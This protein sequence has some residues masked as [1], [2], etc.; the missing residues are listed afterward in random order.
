MPEIPTEIERKSSSVILKRGRTIRKRSDILRPRKYPSDS[1]LEIHQN[2]S[3]AKFSAVQ[4]GERLLSGTEVEFCPLINTRLINQEPSKRND[5]LSGNPAENLTKFSDDYRKLYIPVLPNSNVTEVKNPKNSLLKNIKGIQS[6]DHNSYGINISNSRFF[7]PK[8][9]VYSDVPRSMDDLRFEV[10]PEMGKLFHESVEKRSRVGLNFNGSLPD[11]L[12]EKKTFVNPRGS[13]NDIEERFITSSS[14]PLATTL[15]SDD[16]M[17]EGQRQRTAEKRHSGPSAAFI[18]SLLGEESSENISA[19]SKTEPNEELSTAAVVTERILIGD[20]STADN[21]VPCKNLKNPNPTVTIEPKMHV[22]GETLQD[23]DGL[24]LSASSN[25]SVFEYPSQ[26]AENSSQSENVSVKDKR[27]NRC[28]SYPRAGSSE[29]NSSAHPTPIPRKFVRIESEPQ[30]KSIFLVQKKFEQLTKSSEIGQDW[31]SIRDTSGKEGATD[32]KRRKF[33]EKTIVKHE[34][35]STVR[36]ERST[37]V[38]RTYSLKEKFEPLVEDVEL[39]GGRSR[40]RKI[41]SI[42]KF[43]IVSAKSRVEFHV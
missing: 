38:G 11:L 28:F 12:G 19:T 15:T 34:P 6:S 43:G 30:R 32:L 10:D 4:V 22:P 20:S 5:K 1:S 9:Y 41:T 2:E 27:L 13:E 37:S 31:R 16:L 18:D 29:K 25:D 3:R 7:V 36:N 35:L 23:N 24:I 39:R 40:S 14:L 8:N 33:S 17:N 42:R 26:I 21:F